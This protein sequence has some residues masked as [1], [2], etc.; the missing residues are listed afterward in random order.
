MPTSS[1]TRAQDIVREKESRGTWDD[2][3]E[4]TQVSVA[5]AVH[6][7]LR[8]VAASSQGKANSTIRKFRSTLLGINPE[9]ALRTQQQVSEGLLDFC[10][11][12]GLTILAELRVPLLTE[13]AASWTCGPHHGSKRL[14][15]LRRFFRFCVDAE[16]IDKNP[17]LALEHPKGRAMQ[18]KPTL[19]FTAEEMQ[20]IVAACAGRPK[21]LAVALLMRHAGLR[22]SDAVTFHQDRR[23][24]DGSIF[25]YMHKTEEPVSLPM[26]PELKA[27]LDAAQPNERG[28]YF[29]SG[30]SAVSTAT[31][32]WR[33]RFEG[34]FQ[35]AGVDH[36]HPH[37]FRD[38]F[39]VDLLLRG[40]PI[41]QVS[42]LPGHSS[43]KIT[44]R[45]YLAFVAARRQQLAESLRRA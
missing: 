42:V 4:K 36:G 38:T 22:I 32:N 34:V 9:W 45:H 2:P 17:T 25:L 24:A 14:Q 37:R 10:R 16:W 33:R 19:P 39:A 20:K 26:H 29:W 27:A 44:E 6:T 43:V 30:A 21:L 5:E 23:R 13:W 12:R 18:A 8:A 3:N 40:V 28:Y 15:L 1:W 7:F 31:D 11:N 41:D 35:A